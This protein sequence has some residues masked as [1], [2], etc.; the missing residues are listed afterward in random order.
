MADA[1][2]N[3]WGRGLNNRLREDS[4][5]QDALRK[6]DNVDLLHGGKPRRREGYTPIFPAVSCDSLHATEDFA[7][8]RRSG[9]LCATSDFQNVVELEAVDRFSAV[10]LNDEMIVMDGR[11]SLKVATNFSYQ[12]LGVQAPA[13]QPVVT[14]QTSGSLFEG[15]YLVAVTHLNEHGEESGT[16]TSARVYLEAD[17]SILLT[18]FNL[19]P[20]VTKVRIYASDANGEALYLRDEVEAVPDLEYTLNYKRSRTK[21][22]TQF[23][24]RLPSSRIV[25]EF[26]GRI[27]VGIGSIIVFSQPL[28]YGLYDST[29]DYIMFASD[30]QGIAA[31]DGGMFVAD[32]DSVSFLSGNNPNTFSRKTVST[33]P[34]QK[35]T[36]SVVDGGSIDPSLQGREVA[37]WWARE[38][39]LYVG[40]PD[41]SVTKLK[42]ADLAIPEYEQGF[43]T[44]VA[45]EGVHQLVS[46]MKN[47]ETQSASA[48]QDDFEI[49][50]H[51]NGI[52]L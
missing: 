16:P 13:Y 46:V 1:N 12:P 24:K 6:A 36:M 2:I 14:A 8:F 45:R 43:I 41:G 9:T 35:G 39:N 29:K 34:I 49:E 31:V 26:K 42:D 7:V 32:E 25:T 3:G 28:Y 20:E 17:S 47:P 30:I 4:L 11:K 44:E 50:V 19:P 5:P 23:F 38:G 52:T 18:G 33:Q 40:M 10:E 15:Y 51:R 37:V 21:L 27:Y 48:F 22:R